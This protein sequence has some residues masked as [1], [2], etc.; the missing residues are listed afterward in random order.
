MV[1]DRVIKSPAVREAIRAKA[2][3]TE[4]PVEKAERLARKYALEIAA[5]YSHAFIRIAFFAIN[6]F[7]QKV[8]DG[9]RVRNFERFT[10]PALDHTIVYVPCHRSH[11]DYLLVSYLLYQNGFVPPHVAAGVNLNLPVLGSWI[12][13][14]GAF[15]V[16]RTFR[17]Q[18]LYSAVF[19]E[20][21]STILAQGVSIE[22]FIEG[23]RSRT[24]RLLPPKAG[25]LA[26]TVRGY[27]S[28]PVRPVMFQPVYIGYEQLLEG[29]AYTKELSGT[30]KRSER[31]TDLFKVF[32]VLRHRYGVAT[33]SFGEPIFLDELLSGADPDWRESTAELN[34]KPEWL[35]GLIDGLG[36]RILTGIN[37]A[38]DVNPVNLLATVLLATP[39][40]ALGEKELIAQL[41]LYRMLLVEGPQGGL[42]GF[43][44]MDGEAII[45]YGFQLGL[46]ERTPHPLGD[47]LSL[48]PQRAV[49]LTYFR[50]NVVHL[51][52]LPSLI[53]CCLLNQRS[54]GSKRLVQIARAVFPFL[55]A[56]LF[57]QCE[58][59]ELEDVLRA[60]LELLSEQG[61]LELS[62]N[63]VRVSRA[64]S[65]TTLEGQ[66]NLLAHCLLQT[67]ERYYITI[68]VLTKNG[69]GT[70]SRGQLEKL[71][72]LTAQRISRLH[73]FEAPEFYDNRLFRQFISELRRLGYLS[74][75]RE[76][77][78]E[79]GEQLNRISEDARFILSKEIRHG[80]IRTAPQALEAE[81]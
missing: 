7:T 67:L 62:K 17:T 55:K 33:L 64:G 40:Q 59:E 65:G 66:L 70:L 37:A 79:F 69:S 5:D 21:V 44:E 11:A 36:N 24:G 18:K 42:I 54:I 23:T 80:I 9:L 14:G 2:R 71:C 26:M 47:I 31:L 19:N 74:S 4:M 6:W 38:A 77:K 41:E 35:S 13:G 75:N 10:D 22:Y 48:M 60:N 12:R 15:Y 25:M 76:G 39:K 58:H 20:Y 57:L 45:D 73:E 50:N 78:L 1:I 63:G 43:T 27:L 8:Y 49:E 61:L 46:M 81:A 72:I 34:G 68:A 32:K 30:A 53:A 29:N 51:F 52:A 16:R 3:H 56:E 28:A